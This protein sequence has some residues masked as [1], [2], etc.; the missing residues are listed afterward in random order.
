[1]SALGSSFMRRALLHAL[2]TIISLLTLLCLGLAIR[3][4]IDPDGGLQT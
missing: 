1:M 4:Y 2:R 3:F